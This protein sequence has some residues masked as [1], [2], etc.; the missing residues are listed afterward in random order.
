MWAKLKVLC[1]ILQKLAGGRKSCRRQRDPNLE[2]SHTQKKR[3]FQD[4]E[5]SDS[6]SENECFRKR[7]DDRDDEED[8]RNFQKSKKPAT[9]NLSDIQRSNFRMR[10]YYQLNVVERVN[11][12]PSFLYSLPV[13]RSSLKSPRERG[14]K[15][16]RERERLLYSRAI[17]LKRKY[18]FV[19]ERSKPIAI[20]ARR[21]IDDHFGNSEMKFREDKTS[22]SDKWS[23]NEDV[24]ALDIEPISRS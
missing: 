10:L 23:D 15:R 5:A 20:H 24:F 11:L 2:D 21:I 18:H 1:P 17:P 9:P 22:Q 6:S 13:E 14:R 4:C 19:V 16:E 3:E 8:R 12:K 7:K